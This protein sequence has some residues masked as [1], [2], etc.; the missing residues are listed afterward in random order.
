MPYTVR[1]EQ[2][3][4]WLYTPWAVGNS[5]ILDVFLSTGR[6]ENLLLVTSL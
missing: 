4:R 3:W 6:Q 5:L 1:K 2:S